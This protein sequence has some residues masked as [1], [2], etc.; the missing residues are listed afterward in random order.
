MSPLA[1][2]SSTSFSTK[3]WHLVHMFAFVIA[4]VSGTAGHQGLPWGDE[5][6]RNIFLPWTT[7]SQVLLSLVNQAHYCGLNL[8]VFS[9]RLLLDYQMKPR[10]LLDYQQIRAYTRTSRCLLRCAR[11]RRLLLDFKIIHHRAKPLLASSIIVPSVLLRSVNH[12]A[13]CS[14]SLRQSSCQVFCFAPSII[15][16]SVLLRS[17][18][19]RAKPLL[20]SVNHRAK[21]LL[22]SVNYRAKPLLASVNHHSRF[23]CWTLHPKAAQPC[24]LQTRAS[25]PL[26]LPRPHQLLQVN[27]NNNHNNNIITLGQ[28]STRP[29]DHSTIRSYSISIR[30]LFDLYSI[31][32]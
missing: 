8:Q 19:H 27:N 29:L 9:S 21:P 32:I 31:S 15:V 17:V 2:S 14:A 4:L 20:R 30:S 23:D 24:D 5:P 22:A 7:P 18:N 25:S 6:P 16:P 3:F 11:Q 10:L 1:L 13:K 26:V 28:S 12:R